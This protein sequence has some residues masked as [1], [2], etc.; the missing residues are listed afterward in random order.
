M[1]S[2]LTQLESF[3]N[4]IIGKCILCTVSILAIMKKFFLSESTYVV[5]CKST[6]IFQFL[7]HFAYL[8]PLSKIPILAKVCYIETVTLT[9]G[10]HSVCMLAWQ[11]VTL[12]AAV[13]SM[14]TIFIDG[15]KANTIFGLIVFEMSGN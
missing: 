9:P 1:E 2:P 5:Y 6:E 15:E 12:Y 14:K 8:C 11:H 13:P 4:T 3:T 10:C 7:Y